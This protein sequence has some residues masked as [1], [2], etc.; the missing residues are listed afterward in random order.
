MTILP[1]QCIGRR[2]V[3]SCFLY[4]VPKATTFVCVPVTVL[5][6]SSTLFMRILVATGIQFFLFL[7]EDLFS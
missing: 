2:L 6:A 7:S 1:Q 4:L 5:F 3:I